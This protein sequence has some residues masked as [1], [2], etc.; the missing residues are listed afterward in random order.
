MIFIFIRNITY[1]STINPEK[2]NIINYALKIKDNSYFF[3]IDGGRE[4]KDCHREGS[5]SRRNENY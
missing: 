4:G 3:V 5:P 1:I 2:I